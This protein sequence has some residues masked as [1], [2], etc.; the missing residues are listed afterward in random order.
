MSVI[1]GEL[2]PDDGAILVDGERKRFRSASDAR[3]SGVAIVHQELS[4]FP[5]LTVAENIA[6]GHEPT[7]PFA[8][9]D[10]AKLRASVGETLGFMGVQDLELDRLVTDLSPSSQQLVEIAKAL[11][12]RPKVLILD[13]PTSSL[14]VQEVGL[15]RECVRRLTAGGASI[16]FVSHRLDEVFDFAEDVCVMR[17]GSLVARGALGEYTRDSLVTKMVGR[18]VEQVY[19][20]HGGGA[21]EGMPP[22]M[23]L[24]GVSGGPVRDLSLSLRPGSI[25]GIG[26]LEGQ[27]QHAVAEMAAGIR[28]P[29]EGAIRLE[30]REVRFSAPRDAL[31]RGI[32]YVPPDRREGGL[33]LPRSVSENI[34]LAALR[35]LHPRG[36]IREPREEA[37]IGPVVDRLRLRYDRLSQPVGELSG[38]NQQKVLFGRWLLIQH[39]R[40]LVLD[41]PT[42]GVDVG[43]RAEIYALLSDLTARGVSVL[44][45]S[46]DIMELLGLA[47][48]VHVMYEG[49]LTGTLPAA[50]AT[51]EEVMRLAAGGPQG[52]RRG[53]CP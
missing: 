32:A 21:D 15:L 9:V 50:Q 10:N 37:Q 19:P 45:I 2:E 28:Q 24:S 17:D 6:L 18:E 1:A 46:T 11:H 30:G 33:M 20:E 5:D 48:V 39:L 8:F 40:L 16:V 38:G 44:L 42:R 22:L 52:P 4:L 51:E 12:S 7:R 25:V 36:W 49:R 43:A 31:R 23:E 47:D 26:G 35:R 27:G 29:E 14:G 13:E 53:G 3:R 34:A 41:D